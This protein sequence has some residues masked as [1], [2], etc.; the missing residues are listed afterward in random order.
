MIWFHGVRSDLNQMTKS[1]QYTFS[2]RRV[3]SAY[4]AKS[5]MLDRDIRLERLAY[6]SI[7][8]MCTFFEGQSAECGSQ[9]NC[10]ER[11]ENG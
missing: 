2:S 3:C 1:F 9:F 10:R 7:P 4:V 11:T 6:L 8:A 5:L